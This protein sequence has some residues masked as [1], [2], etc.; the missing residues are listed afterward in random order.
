MAEWATVHQL[1]NQWPAARYQVGEITGRERRS[2]WRR[3]RLAYIL[4]P[5]APPPT[6]CDPALHPRT[7]KH[8]HKSLQ[9]CLESDPRGGVHRCVGG[10]CRAAG[11]SAEASNNTKADHNDRSEPRPCACRDGGRSPSL[12]R[13]GLLGRLRSSGQPRNSSANRRSAQAAHAARQTFP[14]TLL[15]LCPR[16]GP[17]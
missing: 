11:S 14:R 9:A 8:P 3:S 4:Q 10:A 15:Q 12:A 1:H 2:S 7:I 17:C 13:F 5:A 16:V 6:S